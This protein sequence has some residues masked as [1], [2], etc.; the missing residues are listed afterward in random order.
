MK[1]RS[2]VA[3]AFIVAPDGVDRPSVRVRGS[4]VETRLAEG[5]V[6]PKNGH[7]A[8]RRC[9]LGTTLLGLADEPNPQSQH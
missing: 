6:A 3:P 4:M 7:F 9:P 8:E 5:G 1:G 2:G